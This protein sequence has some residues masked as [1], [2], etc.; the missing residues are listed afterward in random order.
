MLDLNLFPLADTLPLLFTQAITFYREK[1][2]SLLRDGFFTTVQVL[3]YYVGTLSSEQT[4]TI[5]WYCA[6]TNQD[7]ILAQMI[8]VWQAS[9]AMYCCQAALS[10][11]RFFFCS[12]WL[13]EFFPLASQIVQTAKQ[14][15]LLH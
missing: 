15:T 5:N 10:Y 7:N 9:N 4:N 3:E 13:E 14:C 2:K 11:A 8:I 1:I 6:G 12:T